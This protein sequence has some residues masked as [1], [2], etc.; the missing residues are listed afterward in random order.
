[1][2]LSGIASGL[3]ADGALNDKEIRFLEAWL[4]EH[5]VVATAWPGDVLYSRVEDVLADGRI[6]EEERAHL[7]ETLQH[8]LGGSLE[9]PSEHEP[10]NQLAFDEDAKLNVDGKTFC[11]TGD[12]VFG[13]R[14]RCIE[15]IAE[16]GGVVLKGVTQE[17]NYLVVGARGSKEC[18]HGSFGT[19]IEKAIAYKRAGVPILIVR[20]NRWTQALQ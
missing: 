15:K 2:L 11:L 20:E 6:T 9:Q 8:I 17:L 18:K 7:V 1:V 4:R 19:K 13:P 16:R 10:V 12:F 14:P 5:D 3:L